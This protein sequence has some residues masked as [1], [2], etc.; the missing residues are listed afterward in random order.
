[1]NEI[2]ERLRDDLFTATRDLEGDLE[3]DEVLAAARRVRRVRTVRRVVAASGVAVVAT[4]AMLVLPGRLPNTVGPVASPT[5]VDPGAKASKAPITPGVGENAANQ[6]RPEVPGTTGAMDL[7]AFGGAEFSSPSGR[8][9]CAMDADSAACGFPDGMDVTLV[10]RASEI[11]PGQGLK[12]IMVTLN[13][14]GQARYAC[15]AEPAATPL[16]DTAS[17]AWW[18]DTGYPSVE[19]EDGEFAVLPYGKKLALGSF[20]CF[21]ENTGVTCGN[22]DSGKGFKVSRAGVLFIR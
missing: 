1:M 7:V 20:V 3:P 8:I 6:T 21:S 11:C 22:T 9:W 18:T 15:G 10:P 16:V 12:V 5:V 14:R 17:T 19:T 2:E 13:A 4:V